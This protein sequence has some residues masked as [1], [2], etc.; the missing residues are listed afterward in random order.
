MAI[1]YIMTET[2]S[3]YI[4]DRVQ[5]TWD[6]Q[7]LGGRLLES[8]NVRTKGGTLKTWP[9]IQVGKPLVLICPSL[10]P[11]GTVR[12]ITTSPVT[13]FTEEKDSEGD[14]VEV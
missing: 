4:L 6:R 14:M 1:T 3:E 8:P 10:S 7:R 12:V 5:M 2:G 11:A 13:S 9:K